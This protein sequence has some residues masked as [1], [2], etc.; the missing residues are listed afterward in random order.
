M[1]KTKGQE[2]VDR[3]A[4]SI[5][6]F[7]RMVWMEL[8]AAFHAIHHNAISLMGPVSPLCVRLA[9]RLFQR[10]VRTRNVTNS[11]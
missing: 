9:Q 3:F 7:L 10:R 6:A 2:H 1:L 5:A 8:Q 4:A 11:G